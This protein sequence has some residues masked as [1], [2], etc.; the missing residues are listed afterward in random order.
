MTSEKMAHLQ[1]ASLMTAMI[2]IS[3]HIATLASIMIVYTSL[4][5]LTSKVLLLQSR[6]QSQNLD[7][8][9]SLQTKDDSISKMSHLQSLSLSVSTLG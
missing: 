8:R 6:F 4:Q 7:G 2:D 5:V 3:Y 9:V 1:P